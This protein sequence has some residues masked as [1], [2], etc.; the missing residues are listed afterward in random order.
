MSKESVLYQNEKDSFEIK[1]FIFHI[2]IE[3]QLQPVYLDEVIL[4]TE[5]V[6]FFKQR[7]VDVSEGVQHIFEARDKSEFVTDCS[8]LISDPDKNFIQISKKLAYSFKTHHNK[9]TANGVFITALVTV[10][11]KRDL[12]F[13]LKIDHRKVYQY[14][15]KDSKALLTELTRTFVEDRK[16]IQK[17]ALIDVSDYYSWDV[18][19]KERN[20]PAKKAL[21]D[22][23]AAFLTVIE[24]DTPSTLTPK[25]VR[26]VRE[27]AI[28]HI[29]ELDDQQDVSS[30]KS[31]AIG[32]LMGTSVFKTD[33]FIDAVILDEDE[34]RAGRLKTSLKA[35]FD[36]I[37]L[38]GQSFVPNK[39]SLT[40]AARKHI[41][42]TAEGVKIEWEGDPLESNIILP[43]ERNNNDGMF[44]ILI[45][46]NNIANA[47]RN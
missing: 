2:I 38:T 36:E 6:I 1:K 47:D 33:D 43:A 39:T 10:E 12:I 8:S 16:A 40:P 30:Y 26:A 23:F 19:A 44:H 3:G 15:L 9:Q 28:S 21:R 27:W 35:H 34:D 37:G 5:Q 14:H 45:K 22:Y 7:L 42:E 25:A 31:R 29:S 18:L 41:R 46:T 13:L 11:G 4:E 24:K 32:Y 17:S 20:P